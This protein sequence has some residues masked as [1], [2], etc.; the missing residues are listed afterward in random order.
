L[1]L[2]ALP[3]QSQSL[4]LAT[5][6]WWPQQKIPAKVVKCLRPATFV[7]SILAQSVAGLVAQAV[8]EGLSDEM[9]WIENTASQYNEWYKRCIQRIDAEELASENAWNLA[10]KYKN[11]SLIKGYVLYKN[12][13]LQSLNVA[14]VYAGLH[15]GILVE[16]SQEQTAVNKGFN[17]LVDARSKNYQTCFNEEK[18]NLNKRMIVIVSPTMQNNRDWA[19][20]QKSMVYYGVNP[21]YE[22]I[23]EWMEPLSPIVGW[24][25]GGESTHVAP[26]SRW[27][28][29]NTASDFCLNFP[30][31]SAG[32]MNENPEKIRTI[33]PNDIDFNE[34]KHFHAF[35]MSDG[36]NMQWGMNGFFNKEYFN[37]AC[38]NQ[39]AT[40][41]TSCP[42]NLSMMAPDVYNYL[43]SN[44]KDDMSIVEFSGG[45]FYPDVFAENRGETERW[46][47]LRQFARKANIHLKRT[48]IKVLNFITLYPIDS[49]NARKAYQI[50]AEEI[51]D[52]TGMTAIQYN[53]Y[54]N[55]G[56]AIIWV[57]NKQ[58][59]DIPVVT[60]RYSLW[61]KIDKAGFGRP[62]Q[63]AGYI[64]ADA[65]NNIN[66]NW[67]I[68]HA[69]SRYKKQKDG[70]IIDTDN[71]APDGVRGLTPV[72][73]CKDR[74]DSS[75]KIISIEEL[76]WRIR[77]EYHP[78]QI[79][80]L[81]N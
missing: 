44:K 79:T 1:F 29:F 7:E 51:D 35:M 18:N 21:L 36:D 45:Y 19:I 6:Y 11:A 34:N 70:S 64:N 58:N 77:A 67:T 66:L 63:I 12:D 27:G 55:G 73:W 41:W 15:Q 31:L 43:V 24:N 52:L 9:V 71:D 4:D 62:D 69:W 23:L 8:N 37:N 65:S 40:S 28:H 32:S 39:M 61:G 47:I 13:G 57:K 49:E 74:L 76:L 16:E 80:N 78:E 56:G 38:R 50:Y 48:G 22:S 10:V 17:L 54:H 2:L 60:A 30:L 14:T 25:E 42:L 72:K 81:K 75:V 33:D 26:P 59:I 3:A 20:A 46:E 5:A 53:P 68:V